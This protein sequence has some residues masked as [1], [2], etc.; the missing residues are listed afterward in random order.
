MCDNAAWWNL[1]HVSSWRDLSPSL[2]LAVLLSLGKY[3]VLFKGILRRISQTKVWRSSL[4]AHT[5][6][7][8]DWNDRSERAL[9]VLE[10]NGHV[11]RPTLWS[12][13]RWRSL[14]DA[15]AWA[16]CVHSFQPL[17]S[18]FSAFWLMWPFL[19]FHEALAVIDQSAS[20]SFRGEVLMHTLLLSI[21]FR[22]THSHSTTPVFTSLCDLILWHR[23]ADVPCASLFPVQ[24]IAS[25]TVSQGQ[26]STLGL[27]AE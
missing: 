10:D 5:N 17:S 15:H 9:I 18:R 3:C 2:S 21:H 1:S 23:R 26:R 6:G 16:Q 4:W 24:Q 13:P 14:L 7:N 19:H 22:P 12:S 27:V 20:E 25:Q 11:T 8:R